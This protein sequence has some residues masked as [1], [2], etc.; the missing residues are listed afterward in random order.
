VKRAGAGLWGCWDL[1]HE[2]WSI[3]P[4]VIA[5]AAYL[6][7]TGFGPFVRPATQG[8]A[9]FAVGAGAIGRLQ[10]VDRLALMVSIGAQM[11][12][13]RPILALGTLGTVRQLAPLSAIVQ[14]G[15]EW[16]F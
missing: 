12:L 9:S 2:E 13:V 10:A 5:S 14:L 16:I 15:P 4:C 6:R 3:S 1:H 7:A 8:E 11:E